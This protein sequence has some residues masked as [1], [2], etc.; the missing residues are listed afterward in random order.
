MRR[1][2]ELQAA[3]TLR[4]AAYLFD[5]VVVVDECVWRFCNEV[6]VSTCNVQ[7]ASFH[8]IFPERGGK[9]T[10]KGQKGGREGGHRTA[11]PLM[12]QHKRHKA[13]QIHPSQHQK[14]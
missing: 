4:K 6:F 9:E 11:I 10:N 1:V 13:K 12:L 7:L 8:V 5:H 3:Q 2:S 14:E